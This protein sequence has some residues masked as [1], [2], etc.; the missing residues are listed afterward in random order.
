MYNRPN[1]CHSR[2]A[3]WHG[4]C[5]LSDRGYG[6]GRL[7]AKF[8]CVPLFCIGWPMAHPAS[9]ANIGANSID[10]DTIIKKSVAVNYADWKAQTLYGH[11]ELDVKAKLDSNGINHGSLSKTYEVMMIEGSPYERLVGIGNEPLSP[12]LQQQE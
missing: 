5:S 8:F 9:A 6:M 3:F 12:D 7:S 2:D 11:R 10:T 1:T 4:N